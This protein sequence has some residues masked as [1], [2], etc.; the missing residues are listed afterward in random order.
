MHI[1]MLLNFSSKS[2]MHR[3][4]NRIWVGSLL[5]TLIFDNRF[6]DS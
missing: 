6:A 5:V 1:Y 2:L 4:T 3:A